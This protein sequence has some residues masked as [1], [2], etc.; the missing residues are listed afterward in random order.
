MN[1]NLDLN[2][3]IKRL[4]KEIAD[5]LSYTRKDRTI[6]RRKAS[7]DSKPRSRALVL[8]G[9][10]LLL[11]ILLIALFLGHRNKPPL[12]NTGVKEQTKLNQLEESIKRLEGMEQKIVSLEEREKKLRYSFAEMDGARRSLKNQVDNPGQM[13]DEQ[14]KKTPLTKI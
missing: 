13:V 4:R 7:P 14:Q 10:G 8:A 9:G 2:G 11:A 5:D 6:R 12:G 3:E 1:A